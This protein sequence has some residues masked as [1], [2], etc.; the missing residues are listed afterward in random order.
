MTCFAWPPMTS[1]SAVVAVVSIWAVQ[2]RASLA[3]DLRPHLVALVAV[4][5]H[6]LL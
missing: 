5:R 1:A 2:W 6:Q 3:E 4:M